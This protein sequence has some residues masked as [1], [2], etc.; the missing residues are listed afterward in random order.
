[1]LG[2]VGGLNRAWVKLIENRFGKLMLGSVR[3]V[4][5]NGDLYGDHPFCRFEL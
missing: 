1:M 2:W 5:S 4:L 3:G